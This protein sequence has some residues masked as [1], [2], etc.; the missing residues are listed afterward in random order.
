MKKILVALAV[1]LVVCVVGLLM[2]A[3]DQIAG[4]AGRF[5]PVAGE[6][7]FWTMMAVVAGAALLPCLNIAGCRWRWRRRWE[8]RRRSN[9]DISSRYRRRLKTNPKFKAQRLESLDEIHA[10][11]DSLQIDAD[12]IIRRTAATVFVSTAAI[13][14]RP[15]RWTRGPANPDP[16][17]LADSAA[18]RAASLGARQ[19]LPLR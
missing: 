5:H 6:V 16:N 15:A 3:I 9:S 14:E 2:T 7:A 4:F 1:L 10:A 18:L 8:V 11:L 13:A 12:N 17:G 19:D